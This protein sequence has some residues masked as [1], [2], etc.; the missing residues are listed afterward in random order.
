QP[1]IPLFIFDS[2][3]LDSKRISPARLE[4]MHNAIHALRDELRAISGYFLIQHGN[5]ANILADI[6]TKTGATALFYGID[7]TPYAKKRDEAITQSLGITI[8]AS[9]D[10]LLVPP[11]AIATGEGKPYTVFTPFKNKWRT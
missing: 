10:R 4:F 9:H 1:I 6:V 11:H 3:I 2:A 5:P 7:Y 8:H